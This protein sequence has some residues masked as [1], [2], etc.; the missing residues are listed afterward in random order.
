MALLS[1]FV[2]GASFFEQLLLFNIG[3]LF[4]DIHLFVIEVRSP[5][6]VLLLTVGLMIMGPSVLDIV[7]E[8]YELEVLCAFFGSF[9]GLI[10]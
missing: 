6:F 7:K 2:L 10:D 9:F 4:L 8:R 5:V 1:V 3:G